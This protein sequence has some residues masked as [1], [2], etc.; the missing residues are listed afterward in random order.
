MLSALIILS[1]IILIGCFVVAQRMHLPASTLSKR[2]RIAADA[3]GVVLALSLL[4]LVESL[5]QAHQHESFLQLLRSGST[6]PYAVFFAG[7]MVGIIYEYVGQFTFPIWYYPGAENYRWLLL[8]LPVF[9]G[10]FML[11]MQDIWAL[12]NNISH[13]QGFVTGAIVTL[14]PFAIIE[15]FNM[16]TH[17]WRYRGFANTPYFLIPGWVLLTLTF[18]GVYNHIFGSPF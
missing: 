15:G 9:W 17:S 16:I 4:A 11:I 3:V 14:V 12:A 10:I 5:L 2:K 6:K 13:H 18:V 7:A 8:G 1:L